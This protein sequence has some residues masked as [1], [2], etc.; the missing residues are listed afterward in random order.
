MQ[1]A[2]PLT[3]W[4]KLPGRRFAAVAAPRTRSGRCGA[5]QA[6]QVLAASDDAEWA[7]LPPIQ[8][9]IPPQA[10]VPG[11][12]WQLAQSSAAPCV[13]KSNGALRHVLLAQPVVD[14]GRSPWW[15]G[16]QLDGV[17]L[18]ARWNLPLVQLVKEP[19]M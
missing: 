14:V 7:K 6:M 19:L 16:R 9:C 12:A 8:F 11:P 1:S 13:A 4:S 18:P 3:A 17:A 5:W 2:V 15:Q 10:P